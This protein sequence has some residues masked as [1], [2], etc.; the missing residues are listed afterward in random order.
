MPPYSQRIAGLCSMALDYRSLGINPI[1]QFL[2][3]IVERFLD[4]LLTQV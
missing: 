4:A 3:P 2:N 1:P